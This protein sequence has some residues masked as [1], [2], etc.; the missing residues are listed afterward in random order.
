[1]TDQLRISDSGGIESQPV[2][3]DGEP[4]YCPETVTERLFDA[5]AFEQIPGQLAIVEPRYSVEPVDGPA[6]ADLW[7]VVDTTG[8]VLAAYRV[9]ERARDVAWRCEHGR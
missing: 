9:F 8:E 2:T 6:G 3:W 4:L 1:M 5:V 7:G